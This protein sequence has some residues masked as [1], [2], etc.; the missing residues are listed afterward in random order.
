MTNPLSPLATPLIIPRGKSVEDPIEL[1]I[2]GASSHFLITAEEDSHAT[3]ALFLESVDPS[4][5]HHV[6]VMV[7]ENDS[8]PTLTMQDAS[9]TSSV[10]IKQQSTLSAGAKIHWQNVSIG[11]K[12]VE[13]DLWSET[14]GQGAISQVDWV[15]YV[16]DHERQNLSARNIFSARDGGG[17]ITLK[18]VAEENAQ[19]KCRGMIEIGLQGGGT[20][21]YLTE[22]VLMLDPTAKVDAIP[23]LEIRTNDVKASH[24]ATVARV[25][26]EDLFYFAAR[27]IAPRDARHMYV[28]GFLGDLTGKIAS[29]KLREAVMERIEQKYGVAM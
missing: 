19:A 27:G 15:F 29:E 20:D 5:E 21:T 23:G 7:K 2:T 4:L 12:T 10:S 8:L 28:R 3:V 26:P 25:T 22:E 1:R 9:R 24:S 13:H 6:E 16:K 11:G 18:G 17:E 14:I